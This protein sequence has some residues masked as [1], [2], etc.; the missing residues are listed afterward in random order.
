[1]VVSFAARVEERRR[2]E[3]HRTV[4]EPF[5]TVPERRFVRPTRYAVGAMNGP[6]VD[7]DA[8]L[9]QLERLLASAVFRRAE[10]SSALLRYIVE[11]TLAGRADRL[12]EYTLGAEALG[13]GDTF[14]PRADPVVRA[15]ASRLRSRLEQ[16]YDSVG[17]SD[18]IRITL[19]KGGYIPEFLPPAAAPADT[20]ESDPPP[21]SAFAKTATSPLVAWTLAGVATVIAVALWFQAPSHPQEVRAPLQ[22]EVDL[23]ADGSLASDVGTTVVLSPD[24]TRIVFVVRTAQGRTH[25][26]MRRLDRPDATR[27][28]GTDGARAPFVSFDGRWVGFWADGKL[29][30]VGLD[31][32]APVVLCDAIDLLGAS[33]GEDD[34]IV[35]AL[36]APGQLSRIPGTG[37]EPAVVVD[38]SAESAA[39]RWPQLLPGDQ[40]VL[41]TVMTGTGADRANIEAQSLRDGRRTVLVQGAT[42]GRYLSSGYLTYVNQ[43]TL[44]AIRFDPSAL[45]VQGPPM[46][47]LDDVAYSPLFGYAQLAVSRTGMLVY[48]R[49]EE[50]QRS[51]VNR[52]DRSGTITSLVSAPGRY[53][54]IRLSPDGRRLA[55]TMHESGIATI[56]VYDLQTTDM[57]RVTTRPGE[58]TGL[59]W[60]PGGFLA[61]GGATGV[62]VVRSDRRD[63]PV[64]L[65]TARLAQTPWSITPDGQRL[66]YYER[67]AETGLDLWTVP[68]HRSGD[69]FGAGQPQRFVGTRSFEVYPS[70]SP[71]GRWVA[72]A[73][74][75]SGSWEIY[76]RKFPDDG[77]KVRVSISGGVVTRWS[78]KPGHLFYRNSS[79]QVMVVPYQADGGSFTPGTPRPWSTHALAETGVFPNF[80]VGAAGD[81]ILALMPAADPPAANHVTIMINFDEEIRRRAAM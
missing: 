73:S 15:E 46:P 79:Q 19:T 8:V 33:W 63:D 70:F 27:L 20:G 3:K 65:M 67:S 4:G 31:G 37:G 56:A 36:G 77:T 66:A 5:G 35:A 49:G 41:Y 10:R 39:V 29:K 9:D 76:V 54:W 71:D 57:S 47:L 21:R 7:R 24:G 42:F 64:P 26:N 53:G 68:I 74:N 23:K 11:Q 18:P 55:L 72:Y 2:P 61:F 13:R 40:A 78:P 62:G 80:D 75:E 32:G 22:F 38:L 34:T 28:A 6:A 59:T 1:M 81:E 58:Y 60:L 51:V 52:I 30:K 69:R 50:S 14:D 48:R 25:L 43:G 45:A 12:K 17:R 44:Y 16:Y